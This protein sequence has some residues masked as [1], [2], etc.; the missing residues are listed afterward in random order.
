[1]RQFVPFEDEWDMLE[2]LPL[3]ALVPYQTGVRLGRGCNGRDV[4]LNAQ[5]S[6]AASLA[7]PSAGMGL[8]DMGF[9]AMARPSSQRQG[10]AL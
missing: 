8:H 6:T 9:V 5:D 4:A 10:K 1:M 7:A 2:A 3:D